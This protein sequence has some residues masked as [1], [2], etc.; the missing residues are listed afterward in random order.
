MHNKSNKVTI[1]L[2]FQIK[3]SKFKIKYII[4]SNILCYNIN[5]HYIIQN[6]II[7]L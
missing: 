7:I 6:K 2:Y 1:I 4:L 3:F 5:V